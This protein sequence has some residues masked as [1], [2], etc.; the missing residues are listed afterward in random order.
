MSAPYYL[1]SEYYV[2]DRV[3]EM[4]D[5]VTSR[6]TENG[7]HHFYESLREFW[8]MMNY[9]MGGYDDDDDENNITPIIMA[10]FKRAMKLI[11]FLYALSPLVLLLE[12]IVFK[13]NKWRR[14]RKQSILT[15]IDF[16]R[17]NNKIVFLALGNIRDIPKQQER[18]M[19]E[20]MQPP[21]RKCKSA[22]I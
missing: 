3:I 7:L 20:C 21:P 12:I 1:E 22:P 8:K 18:A 19:P 13:W 6:M 16:L 5:K 9:K 17:E 4:V 14:Q 11:W 2:P 15:F 10:Q